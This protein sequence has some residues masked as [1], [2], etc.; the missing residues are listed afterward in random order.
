MKVGNFIHYI[1]Y[2][3]ITIHDLPS[4]NLTKLVAIE[5]G[6]F[7]S[8]FPTTDGNFPVRYVSLPEGKSPSITI[9]S[10]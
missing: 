4:G 10:H 1:I 8:D 6:P 9:K 7:I 3:A 5:N 2:I